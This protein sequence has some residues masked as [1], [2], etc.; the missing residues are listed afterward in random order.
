MSQEE[1]S[2]RT[3]LNMEDACTYSGRSLATLKNW[4][5]A[6]KLSKRLVPGNGTRPRA[7]VLREDLDRLMTATVHVPAVAEVANPSLTGKPNGLASLPGLRLAES[8]RTPA[9]VP[10][11]DLDGLAPVLTGLLAKISAPLLKKGQAWLNR[12]A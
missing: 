2:S 7:Q 6:Q 5:N 11:L 9:R 3:W 8:S 12:Q 4:V 10:H 1:D